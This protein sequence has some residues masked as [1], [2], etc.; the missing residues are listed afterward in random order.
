MLSLLVVSR[1][2]GVEICCFCFLWREEDY[3]RN[4]DIF[5]LWLMRE[6]VRSRDEANCR[7]L[8]LVWWRIAMRESDGSVWSSAGWFI[9][10][11]YRNY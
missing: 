7:N 11:F 4:L 3:C 2:V 10:M 6:E 1:T 5:C 9:I 8:V